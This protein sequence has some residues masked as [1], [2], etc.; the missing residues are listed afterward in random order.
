MTLNQCCDIVRAER[1]SWWYG[2]YSALLYGFVRGGEVKRMK[3]IDAKEMRAVDGGYSTNCPVCG[4]RVS[5]L[6]LNVWL[7]GKKAAYA[8]AQ[9]QAQAR[10]YTYFYG[11]KK[12]VKH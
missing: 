11:F 7:Y 5:V 1:K 9:W 6:F 8:N 3:K 4:K 10:H 2:D 12:N